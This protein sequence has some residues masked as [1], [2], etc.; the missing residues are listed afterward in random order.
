MQRDEFLLLKQFQFI[1]KFFY[2]KFFF[3]FV[4]FN[5]FLLL[6]FASIV[7]REFFSK[8]GNLLFLFN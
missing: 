3:I 4:L 5:N 7:G 6:M 8:S 1:N 2:I